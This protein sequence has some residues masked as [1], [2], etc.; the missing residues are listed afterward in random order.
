MTPTIRNL[1]DLLDDMSADAPHE[2]RRVAQIERRIRRDARRRRTVPT[3]LA[4][5]VALTAI[6]VLIPA[7]LT[8]ASPG[9]PR[10]TTA[11]HQLTP[12]LPPHFTAKDGTPYRRLTTTTLTARSTG[13]KKTSVTI[14]VSGKPLDVAGLCDG[15]PGKTEAPQ[16][17][18][19]GALTSAQLGCTRGKDVVLAPLFLPK[20]A[21]QVTVT[22]DSTPWECGR[23]KS[24]PCSGVK[25][26][27]PADWTLAVYEWTPP[28]R[29]VEPEP[30]KA[31]PRVRGGMRLIGEASGVWPKDS[32][33]TMTITSPGGSIG[34]DYLCTGDLAARLHI[35]YRTGKGDLFGGGTCRSRPEGLDPDMSPSEL[36]EIRVPKGQKVTISG[37]ASMRGE[38]RNRQVRYL[39]GVYG[40]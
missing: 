30:I 16:I 1:R 19:N 38:G 18:V 34:F 28:A 5:A 13:Q 4:G 31:L 40:K 3:I 39:I 29:P 33:F 37:K 12:E 35:S 36:T 24:R 26:L 10:Q 32:S 22:F 23:S 20:G 27:R 11:A 2:H 6:S 17:I 7:L 8:P 14:P 9:K 25:F 15:A 21:T